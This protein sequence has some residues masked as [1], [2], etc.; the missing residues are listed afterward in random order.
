[1]I[2]STA[3]ALREA[4]GVPLPPFIRSSFEQ[5]VADTRAALGESRFGEIWAKGRTL[6]LDAAIAYAL[7]EVSIS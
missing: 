1:M 2:F 3:E 7:A 4:I 6:T 5:H